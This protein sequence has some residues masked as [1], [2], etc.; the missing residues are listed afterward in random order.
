M[1]AKHRIGMITPSVNTALEPLTVEMISAVDDDV[2]VHFTRLEVH[3]IRLDHESDRQFTY[4]AFLD[5]ARLL[6]R[7]SSAG[8]SL[9]RDVGWMDGYRPRARARAKD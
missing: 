1:L 9:E 5:A 7:R 6:V 8:R 3:D 4:E 2:S